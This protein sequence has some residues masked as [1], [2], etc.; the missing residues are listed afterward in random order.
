MYVFH[1]GKE[2]I[3]G[4]FIQRMNND[5]NP[6]EEAG[7]ILGKSNE[8]LYLFL[9]CVIAILIMSNSFLGWKTFLYFEENSSLLS[10]N[11]KKVKAEINNL[12]LKSK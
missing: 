12:Y 7:E 10:K 3:L 8:L 4:R 6:N 11:N 1:L 9:C 2:K 5:T